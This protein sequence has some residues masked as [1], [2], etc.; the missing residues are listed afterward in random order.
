MR[1]IYLAGPYRASTIHEIKLNIDRAEKY[2]LHLW[3]LGWAVICPHKNTALLDGAMP[4][5]VWLE[6]DLAILKKCDAIAMM[7]GWEESSGAFDEHEKAKKW[8]KQI[9]YMEV[10]E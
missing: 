1:V 6:G 2:A 3:A 5:E 9:I 8:K 4:D 10:R 7:P